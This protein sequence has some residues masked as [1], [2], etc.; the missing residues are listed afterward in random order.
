MTVPEILEAL[1]R[2]FIYL[3][4]SGDKLQVH[5]CFPDHHPLPPELRAEL[6]THKS[7]LL[8]S[9][10]FDEEADRLLLESSL[11]LAAAW[12]EGCTLSGPPWEV[13][14]KELLV[15]Y[16]STERGR[17]EKAIEAREQYA[18]S[19]FRAYRRVTP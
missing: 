6:K 2:H 17:L 9:L 3:E 16:R 4:R 8:A 15:A 13:S 19:V 12:P 10:S 11:R 1:D 14:E 5:V 18:T 7:E